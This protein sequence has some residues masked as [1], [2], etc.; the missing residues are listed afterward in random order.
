MPILAPQ[1]LR[2]V[3][4]QIL[5]G[6][7]TPESSASCVANS[8]VHADLTGHE[9]HGVLRIVEYLSHIKLGHIHPNVLPKVIQETPT[10]VLVDGY[11]GFGQV[12]ASWVID[13]L[14]QKSLS[15]SRSRIRSNL[16]D[17]AAMESPSSGRN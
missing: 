16:T 2:E 7:G 15:R 4:T 5:I 13:Q 11:Q 14:V 1:Y 8:L 12:I 9:S 17:M 6:A 10:T 3:A